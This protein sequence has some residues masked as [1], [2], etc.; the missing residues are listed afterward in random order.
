MYRLKTVPMI[1]VSLLIALIANWM[2]R[3]KY[4]FINVGIGISGLIVGVVLSMVIGTT[5]SASVATGMLT[6]AHFN[7]CKCINSGNDESKII[8]PFGLLSD[9]IKIKDFWFSI[10]LM[11]TGM[12]LG[13]LMCSQA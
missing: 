4:S 8:N 5:F 11:S 9:E 1:I 13:S 10:R 2:Y 7:H 12:F 6:Y 3:W